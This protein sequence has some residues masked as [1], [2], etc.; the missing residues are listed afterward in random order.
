MIHGFATIKF[1]FLPEQHAHGTAACIGEQ[2][3]WGGGKG[4]GFLLPS[5]SNGPNTIQSTMI[6]C[7]QA[8][9]TTQEAVCSGGATCSGKQYARGSSI[10]GSYI[11]SLHEIEDN[12][13]FASI[14]GTAPHIAKKTVGSSSYCWYGGIIKSHFQTSLSSISSKIAIWRTLLCYSPLACCFPLALLLP[15]SMLL[16]LCMLLP[17]GMMFPSGHAAVPWASC[18]TCGR[19]PV[20]PIYFEAGSSCSSSF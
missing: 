2:H 14:W 16:P 1:L 9:Q 6:L 8:A 4:S 5:S 13:V 11:A 7:G 10:T 12:F 17:L 20:R 18:A 3:A 15:L 19:S